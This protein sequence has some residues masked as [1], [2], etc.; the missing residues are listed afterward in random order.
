VF[1][2][3]PFPDSGWKRYPTCSFPRRFR[4]FHGAKIH[5]V[6]KPSPRPC[7][8]WFALIAHIEM[9]VDQA[10]EKRVRN[11]R[12]GCLGLLIALAAGIWAH[13][14]YYAVELR[15]FDL[16]KIGG[17]WFNDIV[18]LLWFARF[19]FVHA[20]IGKPL[21]TR[22]V[23]EG[24]ATFRR[25][26]IAIVLAMAIDFSF[27]LYLMWDEGE[28]YSRG[29]VTQAQ[30]VL[31]EKHE[32]QK[33]TWYDVECVFTDERGQPHQAHLRV[34]A[35]EH[36]FPATLPKRTAELLTQGGA[37]EIRIRYDR[38]LP[39]RA[40]FDGA[41]W[42]DGQA[43]YWFSVLTLFFQALLTALFLLFLSRYSTADTWPWWSDLSAALPL[44][45]ETFWMF[46]IG[47]IDRMMDSL[48]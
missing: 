5:N 35:A 15:R 17:L 18:G 47:I 25:V 27:T 24:R 48:S 9:N 43:L 36:Q 10:N 13:F 1:I 6:L 37:G 29:R 45:C 44:T 32:R 2:I 30:V 26:V 40:W 28:G 33:A 23:K 7:K 39:E 41:T 46:T 21:P 16:W 22:P 34:Q 31:V 42:D 11:V 3:R 38:S 14:P 20:V 19:A 8:E 4:F 12:L